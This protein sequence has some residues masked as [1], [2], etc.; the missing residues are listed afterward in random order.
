MENENCGTSVVLVAQ[1]LL[2]NDYWFQPSPA[3]TCA[4][5]FWNT[6]CIQPRAHFVSQQ[7]WIMIGDLSCVDHIF[8][9][10]QNQLAELPTKS[11]ALYI[12]KD[13]WTA[14]NTSSVQKFEERLRHDWWHTL[15]RLW[16]QIYTCL[17]CLSMSECMTPVAPEWQTE[18]DMSVENCKTLWMSIKKST[19]D[20]LKGSVWMVCLSACCQP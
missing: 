6:S 4:L 9:K 13:H 16:Y 7:H 11:N 14:S 17:W 12:S 15:L 19:T 2:E 1:V 10:T 20:M 5:R 8:A 3:Y 18:C